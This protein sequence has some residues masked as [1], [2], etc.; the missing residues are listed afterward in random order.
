MKLKF[1]HWILTVFFHSHRFTGSKVQA[2]RMYCGWAWDHW[3]CI[4]YSSMHVCTSFISTL[5]RN[6]CAA[7]VVDCVSC[8]YSLRLHWLPWIRLK[9]TS[10][11]NRIKWILSFILVY[12]CRT[13]CSCSQLCSYFMIISSLDIFRWFHL[14]S[15]RV[16]TSLPQRRLQIELNIEWN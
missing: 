13:F 9:S 7:V 16:L 3:K 5:L 14:V 8:L 2:K 11:S 1:L 15:R 12:F 4:Y 6:R 10:K